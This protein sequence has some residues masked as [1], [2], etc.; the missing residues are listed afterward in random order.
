MILRDIVSIVIGG[1]YR[2]DYSTMVCHRQIQI[3]LH[4]F[5]LSIW[6]LYLW[7]GVSDSEEKLPIVTST[8]NYTTFGS[9]MQ[10]CSSILWSASSIMRCCLVYVDVDMVDTMHVVLYVANMINA[11]Q[12]YLSFGWASLV[13]MELI[14]FVRSSISFG[15][16]PI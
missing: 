5:C 1:M 8:N 15:W 10:K 13:R 7:K 4:V 9:S 3:L 16:F 12:S 11:W 14:N 2:W 6:I